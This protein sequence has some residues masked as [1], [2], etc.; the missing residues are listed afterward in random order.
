MH[1]RFNTGSMEFSYLLVLTSLVIGLILL[2]FEISYKFI[3]NKKTLLEFFVKQ[4]P[5]S[6]LFSI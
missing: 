3:T 6:I 4:D 1:F 5:A 2:T